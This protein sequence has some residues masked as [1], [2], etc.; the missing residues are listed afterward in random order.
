MAERKKRGKGTYGAE[1]GYFFDTL[2]IVC[3]FI[4]RSPVLSKPKHPTAQTEQSRNDKWSSDPKSI[5][6]E[7]RD[8]STLRTY[9][10]FKGCTEAPFAGPPPTIPDFSFAV[11]FSS[12]EELERE[13]EKCLE[14]TRVG[15]CGVG[16]LGVVGVCAV[17]VVV[18]AEELPVPEVVFICELVR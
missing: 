18:V 3:N 15:L 8:T 11:D 16:G 4:S 9:V 12:D 10:F 13:V 17:V 6:F 7:Y 2:F 14:G 1:G 5:E